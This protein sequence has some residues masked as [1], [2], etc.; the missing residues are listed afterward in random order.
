M[1]PVNA[2][3]IVYLNA[4]QRYHVHVLTTPSQRVRTRFAPSPTG[5][6]HIGAFR[7]A[8]FSWL[9]ARKHGG[10]F[11]LRVEDTD[12][13]RLVKGSLES[14]IASLQALGLGYD[15][16]P[17]ISSIAALD[18]SM[19][20][21][22]DLSRV[23]ENGGAFGPYFQSQRLPRYHALIEQLL[24][25]GK[26]YYAFETKEELDAKRTASDIRKVPY[27]YDRQYRDYPL[28]DARIR[29]TQGES[30]VVRIKMPTTGMIEA[31]DLLHGH[32]QWDAT[33]QDDFIILKADGFPPYHFAAMVDDHD[34]EITHVLRGDDW[35]SSLP[36]H[37][38]IF[39]AFGWEPPIF[40]HTPNVLAPGGGKKLSKRHGAKPILGPVPELKDG[41]PTGEITGGLVN[42]EGYLP[43]AII[44]F[45]ALIGWSAGDNKELFTRPE[46]IE[47]FSLERIS[48][49]GGAFDQDKL[50]WMNGLYLRALTPE[51]L[52]AAAKPFLVEAGILSADSPA[53]DEAYAQA[54]L[55][56]EQEKL[57]RLDEAP[58]LIYFFF[59][60]HVLGDEKTVTKWLQKDGVKEYLTAVHSALLILD[61]WQ[62]EHIEAA[63]RGVASQLGR[64]KG[65]ATHPIRITVTG[66]EQG[67][68][69]FDCIHVLGRDRTLER[70]VAAINI[71]KF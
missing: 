11:V 39:R 32:M 41:L 19:Y 22:V 57:T 58:N 13:N 27:T 31:D 49:S 3:R 64:D 8:L 62:T 48:R 55:A 69:L 9:F 5:F 28:E 60:Q 12:Q 36:K 23:P 66:R 6:L 33:T 29:V 2:K 43:D 70:F 24:C 54:A 38:E 18:A 63:I 35:L 40:V 56:L 17:D 59:T 25:E 21:A 51:D 16:G 50:I 67:P 34:M 52:F 47:A 7:T 46:L 68:S 71:I 37:I 30:S 26:A 53:C 61:D 45:L 65:N 1:Y 4:R 10:V 20:G 42:N 15:E 44:N 14:I